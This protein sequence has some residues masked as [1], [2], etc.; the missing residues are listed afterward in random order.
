MRKLSSKL[1]GLVQSDTRVVD[2][3]DERSSG[4][5]I[6]LYTINGYCVECKGLHTLHAETSQEMI[7]LMRMIY[8]CDC[9]QCSKH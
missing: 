5:G 4:D 1:I 9:I 8:P 3:S 2:L 7:E 6:W